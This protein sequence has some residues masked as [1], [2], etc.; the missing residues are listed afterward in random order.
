VS[1]YGTLGGCVP[2][3]VGLAVGNLFV[4]LAAMWLLR[5]LIPVVAIIRFGFALCIAFVLL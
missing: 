5:P 2:V 3:V 4:V 1:F